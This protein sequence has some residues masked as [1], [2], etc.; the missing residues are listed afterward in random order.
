MKTTEVAPIPETPAVVEV[1]QP[2]VVTPVEIDPL[3]QLE[4]VLGLLKSSKILA[5]HEIETLGNQAVAWFKAEYLPAER[6][7]KQAKS[8]MKDLEELLQ[9]RKEQAAMVQM[10]PINP[11]M[12][13]TA[14][15]GIKGL[16]E[17]FEAMQA[18]PRLERIQ[19]WPGLKE[20]VS[21]LES[22]L[23]KVSES[24][25]LKKFLNNDLSSTFKVG[26]ETRTQPVLSRVRSYAKGGPA[27]GK[28]RQQ[29][30]EGVAN[31]LDGML[32]DF[33]LHM[34][35]AEISK[36]AEEQV[37]IAEGMAKKETANQKTK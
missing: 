9:V 15:A 13:K 21:R 28:N 20:K 2:A 3:A 14:L 6:K 31:M 25:M 33:G 1:I 27:K 29:I 16:L 32:K 12:V 26:A 22:A 4:N 36:L 8:S 5:A 19:N 17:D 10:I 35:D 7:A 37:Q 30:I 24:D 18:D 11:E 34:E 23:P